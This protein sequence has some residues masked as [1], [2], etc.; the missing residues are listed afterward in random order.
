MKALDFE[1][2]FDRLR[3]VFIK[4]FHD[5]NEEARAAR[6][7]AHDFYEIS[8]ALSGSGQIVINRR[9]YNLTGG[10]LFVLKPGTAHKEYT[11]GSQK[12]RFVFLNISFEDRAGRSAV[13][14]WNF[15]AWIRNANPRI[16]RSLITR[17]LNEDYFHMPGSTRMLEALCIELFI[18]LFRACEGN[19]RSHLS[20]GQIRRRGMLSS[21]RNYI[22][23]NYSS[24]ITLDD[25][26][27]QAYLSPA[28]FC[29]SFT[30]E[31]GTSPVQYL[32]HVRIEQA[33]KLL[34]NPRSKLADIC[35][36]VGYEDVYYFSRRFKQLA[37]TSPS[38]F[39]EQ[40]PDNRE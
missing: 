24:D 39:R 11:S 9:K 16:F 32:T 40:L 3:P 19:R 22:E 18:E 26:A 20:P 30:E 38:K 5:E 8:Y 2:I 29:A 6:S 12:I 10:E 4:A 21:A 1:K 25:M 28:Y 23:N 35:R 15:P 13:L 31:F 34:E 36:Q 7:H 33:K 14:P 37:G 17:L 27:A